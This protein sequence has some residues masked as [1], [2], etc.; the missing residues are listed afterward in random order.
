[1]VLDGRKWE[2]D[3]DE[4]D[5]CK[6]GF[7][8]RYADL[9]RPGVGLSPKYVIVASR[10]PKGFEVADHI[11]S[12][13]YLRM[14]V[15]DVRQPGAYVLDG[16]WRGH[17]LPFMTFSVRQPDGTYKIYVNDA[18]RTPL[19]VNVSEIVRD[20]SISMPGIIGTFSGGLYNE[21]DPSDSLVVTKGEFNLTYMGANHCG[22]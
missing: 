1:M 20:V 5:S 15:P 22:Y 8:C 19:V 7:S 10:D 16:T 14:Q 13:N 2:P 12:E 17:F 18:R 3:Q 4:Q 11:K 6:A 21:K 9:V